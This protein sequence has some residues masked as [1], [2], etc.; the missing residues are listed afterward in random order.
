MA[1]QHGRGE[2]ETQDNLPGTPFQPPPPT[3]DSTAPS[4]SGAHRKEEDKDEE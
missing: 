2:G 3:P 4:G 1:G